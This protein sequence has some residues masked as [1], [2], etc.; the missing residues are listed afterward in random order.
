MEIKIW[1][2]RNEKNI[3]LRNLSERTGISKTALNYYENGDR[4]PNIE[5]LELIAIALGCRISD[6]YESDFK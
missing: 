5:Q 4:T 2:K 1:Q 3:S 6:L